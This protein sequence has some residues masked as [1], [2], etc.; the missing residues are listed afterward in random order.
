MYSSVKEYCQSCE[1]CQFFNYSNSPGWAP[2]QPIVT[3]RPGQFVQ[4]DYMGPFKVS[5]SGNK[6][7]CLAVDA[8]IKFLWYAATK[9]IDEVSTAIFLF[10]EIVCKVGPIEQIMSDQGGC[11]EG[12]VF[13]H[14]CKLIGSDKLRSSAFHPSGNGGIEIVNKVIKPNL[15][16]FVSSSHDDW[17]LHLGLAVNSY[18]NTLQSSIGMAPS[19]ALFNR[20]PV[21]IADV[22][23]NNRLPSSTNIDNVGEHTLQLWKNAKRVRREISFN[24]DVSQEKQKSNYDKSVRDN[25][26]FEEGQLVKIRNFKKP[27]NS[28]SAFVQKFVGPFKILRKLS[29]LSFEI[30]ALGVKKQVVHYNRLL[31]YYARDLVDLPKL[32]LHLFIVGG[33]N[34]SVGN[35]AGD[36]LNGLTSAVFLY[37]RKLRR[38]EAREFLEETHMETEVRSLEALRLDDA[39]NTTLDQH[40]QSAEESEAEL[41]LDAANARVHLVPGI[42]LA[43]VRVVTSVQ[44]QEL[45]R[46]SAETHVNS[47]GKKQALCWQCESWFEEKT[48]LRVH[49]SGCKQAMPVL[50]SSNGSSERNELFAV[51]SENSPEVQ[52]QLYNLV[53]SLQNEEDGRVDNSNPL[54]T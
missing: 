51:T 1:K 25:R 53:E 37:R 11:F 13:Q 45:V 18:N 33:N 10:N 12:N 16:K 23:C 30:E 52:N 47:N 14:L 2:L 29:E 44:W 39:L 42:V 46:L 32:N 22:I 50:N 21:L 34:Q 7:I 19:E 3:A 27:P 6:Y 48:G 20:P 24:K 41:D 49:K 8:H 15:A 40:F 31:P 43:N 54:S 26:S 17:D 5:K 28:C 35:V 4:L 9:T 38:A 36:N